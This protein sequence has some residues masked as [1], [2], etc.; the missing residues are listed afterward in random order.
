MIGQFRSNDSLIWNLALPLNTSSSSEPK[1][2]L[3]YGRYYAY[4]DPNVN[5]IVTGR[6]TCSA[7]DYTALQTKLDLTIHDGSGK[8]NFFKSSTDLHLFSLLYSF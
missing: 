7:K 6:Y 1:D 2:N 5:G 4:I 8:Q 3:F